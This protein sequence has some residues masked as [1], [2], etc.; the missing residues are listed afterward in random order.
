MVVSNRNFL[1]QRSI[2]RGYVSFREG[3]FSEPSFISSEYLRSHPHIYPWKIPKG[4]RNQR[5]GK[6]WGP[7]FPQ[8]H[9]GK[10]IE[11]TL[12]KTNGWIWTFLV[13]N[14]LDFWGVHQLHA[15]FHT[16]L[17]L[18]NLIFPEVE[19][20]PT[21]TPC[22]LRRSLDISISPGVGFFPCHAFSQ[23]VRI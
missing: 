22:R 1:F 19:G 3:R 10:I 14:S 20:R 7:I 4:P 17:H 11:N 12:P 5:L 2:F 8:D 23:S 16:D 18:V 15:A 6:V 13:S 9:V 21:L